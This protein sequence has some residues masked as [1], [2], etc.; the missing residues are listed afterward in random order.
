M[1]GEGQELNMTVADL[2]TELFAIG[3][4]LDS[5]R[6]WYTLPGT[7]LRATVEPRTTNVYRVEEGQTTCVL[8]GDTK[9]IEA[10]QLRAAIAQAHSIRKMRVIDALQL[11]EILDGSKWM[12]LPLP[13][14]LVLPSQTLGVDVTTERP[15][16]RWCDGSYNLRA[17]EPSHFGSEAELSLSRLLGECILI[18]A[19]RGPS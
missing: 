6:E 11:P 9:G 4:V 3:F 13:G 10:A 17:V 2:I 16:L 5:Q 15:R 19:K 7:T 12:A 18:D 1:G 14:G 8:H